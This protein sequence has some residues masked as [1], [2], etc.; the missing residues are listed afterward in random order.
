MRWTTSCAAALAVLAAVSAAQGAP[1]NYAGGMYLQNF[2]GLPTVADSSVLPV[3]SAVLVGNDPPHNIQGVLGTTGMDGWTM[4]N[5]DGSSLN[6]EFR[7]HD[8]R[9]AGG[10]GRGVLSFGTDGSTERALGALATSNQVGR[11]GLSLINTTGTTL[12]SFTLSYTGEQWRR[13]DVSPVGNTLE[14]AYA[15]TA[16]LAE[17]I[18]SGTFTSV[19]GLSYASPNMQ[20]A[21][22][23]VALDGNLGTNQVAVGGTISGLNWGPDEMLMLRWSGED[24]SGQDNGLAVDGLS[25]S[26]AVPEPATCVLGMLAAFG[27]VS[28]RRR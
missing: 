12:N 17:T 1:V 23:E 6:T 7:V 21:P 28:L 5:Y 13:G 2:D 24:L 16:N 4:S 20:A 18:N 26:A 15:V 11:F 9:Q 14:F 8:G 27:L 10:A 22:L 25:F 3:P 19:A